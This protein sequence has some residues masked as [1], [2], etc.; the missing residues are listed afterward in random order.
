MAS[1]IDQSIIFAAGCGALFIFLFAM[2]R[3]PQAAV[4]I[5]ITNQRDLFGSRIRHAERLQEEDQFV[6]SFAVDK[7]REKSFA[8]GVVNIVKSAQLAI[9]AQPLVKHFLIVAIEPARLARRWTTSL[10]R[11]IRRRFDL[12][13][14]FV[15]EAQ[16]EARERFRDTGFPGED[17]ETVFFNFGRRRQ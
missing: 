16:H 4:R 11:C 7:G 15:S 14:S 5:T 8:S 13:E 12:V 9:V 2:K 1:D 6:E 10:H 17:L 3:G